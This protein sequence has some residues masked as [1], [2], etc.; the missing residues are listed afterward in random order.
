ALHTALG[1]L[2]HDRDAALAAPQGPKDKYNSAVAQHQGTHDAAYAAASTT[3]HTTVDGPKN[4]LQQTIDK[5]TAI[6]QAVAGSS[7]L[8]ASH[9]TA[10]LNAAR[11]AYNAKYNSAQSAFDA[12]KSVAEDAYNAALTAANAAYDAA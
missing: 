10:A 9:L 8:S 5:A 6:Y 3:Y 2:E 7:P 11:D 1:S 12:A 4:T